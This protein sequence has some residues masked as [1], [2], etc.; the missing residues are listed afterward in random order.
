MLKPTTAILSLTLAAG[1]A[2]A[3]AAAS[4]G[5]SLAKLLPAETF[6][7]L[8]GDVDALVDGIRNLDIARLLQDEEMQDFLAPLYEQMPA[9]SRKDPVGSIWSMAPIADFVAGEV[10]I[11]VSGVS[12]E[13]TDPDGSTRWLRVSPDKP[14]SARLFHDLASYQETHRTNGKVVRYGAPPCNRIALDFL[15]RIEPG[16]VVKEHVRRTLARP[17]EF[18]EVGTVFVAGREVTA[19][20][21]EL[22]DSGGIVT[23]LYADMSGDRWLIGGSQA[24]F[25]RAIGGGP[26]EALASTGRFQRFEQELVGDGGALFAFL[27]VATA[28]RAI[29]S[30]IPPIVMEAMNINGLDALRGVG[31][32]VSMVNGGV[33]ESILL[34]YDGARDGVFSLFDAIGGGFPA[35]RN[36]PASTAAFVGVRLDLARLTDE[37]REL[38]TI[39]APRMRWKLDEALADVE[40]EGWNLLDDVI[41]AFG[42]E[43]GVAVTP[44][45]NSLIPEAMLSLEVRD[46]QKFG[47]L[48]EFGRSVAGQEGLEIT[49]LKLKGG[50]AGFVMRVPEA[51][52]QPAF[53]L[54]GNHL[55]G[56]IS[57]FSLKNHLS[58]HVNNPDAETLGQS[59]E[60]LPKVLKGLCGGDEKS[61]AMLVYLDLHST[62]P[63]LYETLAPYAQGAFDEGDL[64][65]DAAML[66]MSET[67]QDYVS[68]LALGV[69]S[70]D[71]GLGIH[72]FTPTGLLPAALTAVIAEEMS[73][74]G[75]QHRRPGDSD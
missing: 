42:S 24:S 57:A 38:A 6:L 62:V 56:A 16:P 10:S 13:V 70:N 37:V 22:P 23:T 49:D 44:P 73:R 41:P 20:N 65:L 17:P 19:V 4:D 54:R 27:D 7:Y 53:A 1:A 74:G 69:T 14:I 75:M 39:L 46:A 55:L 43:I 5:P 71:N 72:A 35:L 33:R 48:L 59:S 28:L 58:R 40:F 60:V 12:F 68:G 3:H 2:S 18:M 31:V 26:D 61:L 52:V 63:V 11:G 8:S 50:D 45:R 64:P 21:I 32:G 29:E 30:T 25:A 67:V 51:P 15:A 36:A 34:S 9:I 66:P 47:R